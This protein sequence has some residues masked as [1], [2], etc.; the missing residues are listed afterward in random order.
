[1]TG[2]ADIGGHG[3]GGDAPWVV[4]F[5]SGL[6]G[7]T[8]ARAIRALRPDLAM[9]YV[10]DNA[11]FPYGDLSET[12]LVERV[13]AILET[14]AGQGD[15]DRPPDA[16]VIACNTASTLCL[17]PLRARF[18]GIE[19]VGTV[20]AIKPA[21]ERTRSGLVSVLA[22]PGTVKRQYTRDLIRSY[23]SRCHV[24]LVGS[25]HLAELA[26]R[27]MRAGFVDEAAVRREIAPC[28]VE[29][30]GRRTDIVV[31]ACTH[32]PFLVNRM[33]KT[34]PWPVDWIDT[35][36]AIARRALALAGPRRSVDAG[37]GAPDV[38]W[39]TSG[40]PSRQVVRLVGGFGFA[41]DGTTK[42]ASFPV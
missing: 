11:C 12:A 37:A 22:T 39:F 38:A 9:T 5:D 18:G 31:L 35:S 3:M 8:V 14:V 42:P 24:R 2:R 40:A 32:Y 16:V 26:E 27:Y 20:P 23:A 30:D 1:M 13:Q 34:A 15:H 6:G 19:I 7:L 25:A 4:V 29:D 28:F 21:A 36:E 10:A 17:P 33:R 41:V